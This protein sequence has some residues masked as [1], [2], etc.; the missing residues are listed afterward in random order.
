VAVDAGAQAAPD[1]ALDLERA[2]ALPAAGGLAPAAAVG[3]ARQHAVF[4]RD[5]ALALAAQERRRLVLDAGG[6]QHAG[7]AERDQYRAFGMPGIAALDRNRTQ[8]FGE[9]AARA[10]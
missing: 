5:P 7:V 8:L 1:Q 4:G 3:G 9:A 6:A 10:C 2:P